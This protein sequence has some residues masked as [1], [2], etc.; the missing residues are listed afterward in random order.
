MDIK[1]HVEEANGNLNTIEAPTDMAL[2]LME[3]LKASDYPIAATC[4]GMALCA[5]CHVEVLD[6]TYA[7]EPNDAEMD[8]LDTLPVVSQSSR[9]AC[10]MPI[11]EEMDGIRIRLMA[12]ATME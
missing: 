11:T 7:E 9:L 2:S 1:I 6:N 8:M 5:S 10:Q 3:I 12:E 4:G